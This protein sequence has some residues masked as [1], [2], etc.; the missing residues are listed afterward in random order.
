MPGV[1]LIVLTGLDP[2]A[3]NDTP[4]AL[5]PQAEFMPVGRMFDVGSGGWGGAAGAVASVMGGGHRV[6]FDDM[7]TQRAASSAMAM[8][9]DGF[10]VAWESSERDG[11]EAGSDPPLSCIDSPSS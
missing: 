9:T 6:S 10:N 7:A 1:L 8:P 5:P 3:L 11:S 4:A 2:E